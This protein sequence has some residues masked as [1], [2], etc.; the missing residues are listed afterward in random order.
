[1]YEM[2]FIVD[3]TELTRRIT[4]FKLFQEQVAAKKNIVIIKCISCNREMNKAGAFYYTNTDGSVDYTCP[5]C[6]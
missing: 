1:M 2:V 6:V 4:H 5:V 3:N